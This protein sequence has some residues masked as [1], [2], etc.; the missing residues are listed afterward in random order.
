[1]IRLPYICAPL[2][3]RGQYADQLLN[4]TAVIFGLS[5]P[6]RAALPFV[7]LCLATGRK[8]YETVETAR[9]CGRHGSRR[10]R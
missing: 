1:M 2:M 10:R 9:R 8:Y 6:I 4:L 7:L 5:R 3:F